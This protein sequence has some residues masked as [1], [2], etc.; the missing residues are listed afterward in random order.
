MAIK[1]FS[2]ECLDRLVTQAKNSPRLRQHRNIHLDYSDPCQRL[3]NAIEPNSYIRPHHHGI[4]S[5]FAMRGLMALIVFNDDGAIEQFQRFGVDSSLGGINIAAGT[6][7][8][9]DKWHTVVSLASGSILLEIKAG[10]FDPSMPKTFAPWA[11]EEGTLE[12]VNY[13]KQLMKKLTS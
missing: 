3:F 4:E 9:L 2:V 6:E 8:P 13:L 7:I 10:P 12:G 11:P 1:V 5:L